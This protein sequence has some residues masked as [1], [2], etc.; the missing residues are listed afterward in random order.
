[1]KWIAEL[2][3]FHF[4]VKYR[5][6]KSSSDCD[7]MSRH[8]NLEEFTETLVLEDVFAILQNSVDAVTWLNA[9]NVELCAVEKNVQNVVTID[10][11][12]LKAAQMTDQILKPVYEA[13]LRGAKPKVKILKSLSRRSRQI[14]RYFQNLSLDDNGLLIKKTKTSTQIILPKEYH[15]IVYTERH[16]NMGHLGT[17][18]V[19]DLAKERFYWPAMV[20]DI[21]H[22]VKRKCR[23]IKDKKTNVPER[24]ELVNISSTAPFEMITVDFLHLDKCRGGFEYV[25]V[26]TD[27]F[28]R[29]AQAFATK[30]NKAKTAA[31]KIFT[32]VLPNFGYPKQIHHDK[33]KEF[34]NNIWKHLQ[35]LSGIKASSTTPYHPMGNGQCE[36]IYT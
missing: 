1:M 13:V 34:N 11:K 26:V 6:G 2:A 10:L 25:L 27:H 19:V 29:Y 9:I 20:N 3:D 33:G 16:Q 35:K 28:T 18:R 5:P 21:E 12:E 8:P 14:L 36:R 17:E 23:C 15:H 7:F 24:A 4:V 31:D 32:E 22:F 30:T